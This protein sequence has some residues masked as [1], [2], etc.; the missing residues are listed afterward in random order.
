MI[1][2]VE[3][4]VWKSD[5]IRCQF[6]DSIPFRPIATQ[7][8][9]V[10]TGG[11][12]CRNFHCTSAQR[13]MKFKKRDYE[14]DISKNIFNMSQGLP[15]PGF[16][17]HYCKITLWVD[18]PQQNSTTGVTLTSCVVWTTLLWL[19]LDNFSCKLRTVCA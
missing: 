12:K 5:L 10:K 7:Q 14:Y 9:M 6:N 19:F 13:C 3:N 4:K 18:S 15:N 2:E 1:F 8:T 11:N 17:V 16:R